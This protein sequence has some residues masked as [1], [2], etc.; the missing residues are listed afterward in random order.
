MIK[1]FF[2]AFAPWH[3]LWLLLMSSQAHSHGGVAFEDD[4]CVINIDFM[5]AH[6]TVFQPDTRETEEFCEDIPD[7]T[8][9]VFVMEY[10]HDLLTDMSIDFR[11]VRDVNNLGRFADWDD[12]QAIE[13][14]E[15]VTVF[16]E[17]PRIEESGFYSTSYDF[18]EKGTYIGVVTAELPEED[19]YYNA[20]FYFRVGGRDWGTI[21]LF[22]AL[23]F[24]LQLGY[25]VSTG[26]YQRW[27][28]NQTR[29]SK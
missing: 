13:D 12:I 5:Q 8:R 14:L 1:L 26:G 7:V 25:W 27:Q 16:Y 28:E 17:Q 15:A 11:I 22:I 20:V 23:A 10:L 9:S 29:I 2:R 24:I 18:T 19:R 6:F 3:V 21:P 4:L